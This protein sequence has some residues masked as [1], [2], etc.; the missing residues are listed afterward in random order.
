MSGGIQICQNILF[1]HPNDVSVNGL[2]MVMMTT[3]TSMMLMIG[4]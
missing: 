3:T 4:Y 1:V 2:M